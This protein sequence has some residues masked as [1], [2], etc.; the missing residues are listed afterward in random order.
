ML[1]NTE[2]QM[3]QMCCFCMPR[4]GKGVIQ[5]SNNIISDNLSMDDLKVLSCPITVQSSPIATE[6]M[7][8]HVSIATW[9]CL[10]AEGM[11]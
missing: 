2:L 9:A 1:A 3:W 8:A 7:A 10:L 6:S 5:Q 4:L 11:L